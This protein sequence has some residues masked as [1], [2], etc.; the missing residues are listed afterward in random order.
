MKNKIFIICLIAA[1]TLKV[2]CNFN[3]SA[4]LNFITGLKTQ[5]NGLSVDDINITSDGKNLNTTT[6]KYGE[7]IDI[8]FE[9]INGFNKENDASFPGMELLVL[10]KAGDTILHN[11]DLYANANEGFKYS[12]LALIG[13]LTL[14]N[15][16][17]SNNEYTLK[18]NIWDKKGDGTFKTQLDFSLIPNPEIEIKSEG[19]EARE[20]YMYSN[21]NKKILTNKTIAFNEEIQIMIDGLS[22]FKAVDNKATLQMSIKV[23]DADDFVLLENKNLL[24]D[25]PADVNLIKQRVSAFLTLSKGR[26]KNPVTCIVNVTDKASDAKINISTN[27]I[28]QQ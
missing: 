23:T 18:C 7:K 20:I 11:K 26:L 6:F 14:A 17:A 9:N 27:L 4:T 22:G 15:P 1:S 24:P 25:Q 2:A 19:L 5:G 21:Q 28:V 8:N 13:K 12:P 16:F 10:S 3:K